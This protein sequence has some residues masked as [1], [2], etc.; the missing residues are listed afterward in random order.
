VVQGDL[1]VVVP[2]EDLREG[3]VHQADQLAAALV[4]VL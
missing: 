4:V 3:Q 2:A 1:R